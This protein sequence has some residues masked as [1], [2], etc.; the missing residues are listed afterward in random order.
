[1]QFFTEPFF[2]RRYVPPSVNKDLLVDRL[3]AAMPGPVTVSKIE[4]THSLRGAE[5]EFCSA[6]NNFLNSIPGSTK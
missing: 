6:V 2:T 3:A 1:M 5:T 4:G